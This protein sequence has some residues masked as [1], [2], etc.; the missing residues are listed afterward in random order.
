MGGLKKIDK[1]P[2]TGFMKAWALVH[3]L[4]PQVQWD[5]MIYSILLKIVEE[6]ERKQSVLIRKWL[7]LAKHLTNVALFS[8]DVP[9]TLPVRSLVDVFKTTGKILLAAEVFI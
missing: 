2:F 3:I 1:S 4:I 6:L 7:G 8:K 5:I 9:I